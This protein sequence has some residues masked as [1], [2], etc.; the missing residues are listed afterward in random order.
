MSAKAATSV[1]L[2][3]QATNIFILGKGFRQFHHAQENECF[4]CSLIPEIMGSNRYPPWSIYTTIYLWKGTTGEEI[5]GG[6][7]RGR[8]INQQLNYRVHSSSSLQI[9]TYRDVVIHQQL[10]CQVEGTGWSTSHPP[11]GLRGGSTE[12]GRTIPSRVE[13][14]DLKFW[15]GRKTSGSCIEEYIPFPTDS[16]LFWNNKSCL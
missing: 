14:A 8:E 13:L 9:K 1:C 15:W 10:N 4:S 2:A 6:V 11:P 5:S 12:I 3:D 16:A 7:K